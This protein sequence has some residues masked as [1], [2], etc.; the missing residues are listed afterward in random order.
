MWCLGLKQRSYSAQRDD[1]F[2][3]LYSIGLLH[4]CFRW[5]RLHSSVV[6]NWLLNPFSSGTNSGSECPQQGLIECAVR[7]YH[8]PSGGKTYSTCPR[9][10]AVNQDYCIRCWWPT[11]FVF[12]LFCLFC[13]RFFS[14]PKAENISWTKREIVTWR[15]SQ[16]VWDHCVLSGSHLRVLI[17]EQVHLLF[18]IQPT[19][20]NMHVDVVK[21]C[22]SAFL[23]VQ[24]QWTNKNV[25]S[26]RNRFFCNQGMQNKMLR[27]VV[28]QQ[29]P[30]L[31]WYDCKICLMF[32]CFFY[33]F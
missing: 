27:Y 22:G 30:G 13:Y 1:L 7:G 28:F 4:R 18:T 24:M 6:W 25:E 5:T 19:M 20:L 31:R 15:T 3:E 11:Y 14:C 26:T 29:I 2:S 33:Y 32:V 17:L 10:D 12:C 8:D 16:S 21:V 9:L 23:C